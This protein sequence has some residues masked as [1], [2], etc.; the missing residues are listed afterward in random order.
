MSAIGPDEWVSKIFEHY[1][2][3][4]H[5]LDTD[6]ERQHLRVL[7]RCP[8]SGHLIEEVVLN[9]DRSRWHL[10][11]TSALV[12]DT[13]YI[14]SDVN[15]LARNSFDAL[16]GRPAI[17]TM[18]TDRVNLKCPKRRCPYAGVKSQAELVGQ[19][20]DARLVRDTRDVRLID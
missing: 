13:D 1:P 16:E 9:T 6:T 17:A 4:L 8:P 15:K 18:F 5:L 12:H 10:Y 2:Q 20:L 7:L 3:L 19:L 11:V 14:V